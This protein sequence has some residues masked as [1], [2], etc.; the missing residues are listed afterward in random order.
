MHIGPQILTIIFVKATRHLYRCSNALVQ[1]SANIFCKGPN[2]K[3]FR[4]CGPTG[5]LDDIYVGR[6]T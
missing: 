5:K 6:H 1:G 4:L 3:Y 2:S